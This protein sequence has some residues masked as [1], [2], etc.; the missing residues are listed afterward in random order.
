MAASR[1]SSRGRPRR[2]PPPP[3]SRPPPLPCLYHSQLDG[4]ASRP[5]HPPGASHRAKSRHRGRAPE[6][7][8]AP[9]SGRTHPGRTH[10][11]PAHH[12]EPRGSGPVQ[13]QFLDG[14]AVAWRGSVESPPMRSGSMPPAA[15]FLQRHWRVPA[16]RRRR[17]PG[18][19]MR[20]GCRIPR[21]LAGIGGNTS[22]SLAATRSVPGS[23]VS[24][25]YPHRVAGLLAAMVRSQHPDPEGA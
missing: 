24:A 21:C 20:R 7:P 1:E 17:T 8:V 22:R 19:R 13:P 12:E 5:D 3:A 18:G 25:N 14:T 11:Q 9:E 16:A 2:R 4:P 23:R 10:Q 6:V 15:L